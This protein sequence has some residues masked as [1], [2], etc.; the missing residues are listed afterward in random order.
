MNEDKKQPKKAR[1][2]TPKERADGEGSVYETTR[3]NAKWCAS[4][5]VWNTDPETGEKRRSFVRGYGATKP[6]AIARRAKNLNKRLTGQTKTRTRDL[7]PTLNAYITTYL[8]SKATEVSPE[9]WRKIKRN[10]E[11]HISKHIGAIKISQ[12]T[13]EQLNDLFYETL[14]E[15]GTSARMNA[16]KDLNALFN[17]ALRRKVINE[18]PLQYVVRPKHQQTQ[19]LE[20]DK[21]YINR[22]MGYAKGM[23]KWLQTEEAGQWQRHYPRI[24]FMFLGLRRAEL[25]GLEWKNVNRIKTANKSSIVINRQL[26]RHEKHTGKSGWYIDERVKTDS[27]NRVIYLPETWR[28][29]LLKQKRL[30]LAAKEEWQ[31]D[32]VFLTDKGTHISYN[33][34]DRQWRKMLLDYIN[35]DGK[36]RTKLADDEYFRPHASRNIT[37][38]ILFDEGV[39]PEQAKEI[40]GHSE[41]IMTL[42][43]THF[44]KDQKIKST[45]RLEDGLFQKAMETLAEEKHHD[46]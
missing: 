13:E 24:L 21:K 28:K 44:T 45:N 19:T 5:T 27:S 26:K 42:Y 17:F 7:S 22:R 31:N 40:L 4:Y 20:Y 34:H 18:N 16:Y 39:A 1:E 8:N 3:G 41:S 15:A 36:N 37:A 14:E 25:L 46:D 43:Y 2:Y 9:T 11:I 35:T 12:I 23:L 30:N 33:T 6:E 10:F 38:S 29:A 32:L